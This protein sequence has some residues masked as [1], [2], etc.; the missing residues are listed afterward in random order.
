MI[1]SAGCMWAEAVATAAI[2]RKYQRRA[3]EDG[4]VCVGSTPL[5]NVGATKPSVSHHAAQ[6]NISILSAYFMEIVAGR[7]EQLQ[8]Q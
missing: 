8:A 3:E 5:A 2:V 4:N 6:G 1:V 7:R